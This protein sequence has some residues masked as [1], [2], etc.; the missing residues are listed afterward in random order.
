MAVLGYPISNTVKQA[1]C[2]Y[3]II[4]ATIFYGIKGVVI[5]YGRGDIEFECKQLKGGQNFNAHPV[6]N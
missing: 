1:S 6:D 5:I 3:F 2:I 4:V